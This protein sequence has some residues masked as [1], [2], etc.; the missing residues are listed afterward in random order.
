MHGCL[1][2]GWY[3]LV[4]RMD[5]LIL[6]LILPSPGLGTE[7]FDAF[8]PEKVGFAV[9]FEE[10]ILPY[11]VV[12]VFVLPGETLTLEVLDAA[13]GSEYAL[14]TSAGSP[15]QAA[16]RTW[17]WKAPQ[18]K[19][20]YTLR[21]MNSQSMESITLYAFVMIPYS[22]LKGEYLNGYRIGRYPAI[23]L[24]QLPIYKPPIGF[25]EVTRENE[26]TLVAPHFKLKQF[27]SK[28][29]GGY[30][31]Y[32]VLKERLLLKLELLLEKVNE[33]GYRCDTFHIMSGFRTPYYN[34]AI[35][36]VKYS[37]HLWGGAADIFIDEDPKDDMMDD[38]NRD[39]KMNYMDAAVLYD[40][41]DDLYGKPF[42]RLFIGGL[43]RYK[44]TDSHGPFIHV[45]VRGFR[46][47]WGD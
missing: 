8:S 9:K 34:K 45:D 33:K 7:P 10:E 1:Q 3:P 44:K 36:N 41:V 14:Q 2:R 26:E 20:L 4:L 31:K 42:Y 37:L 27:I 17:H 24:R 29:G 18:G 25:I 40:I 46:A 35:G 12:G 11:R 15:T 38:L 39:G 13:L 47:R 5:V 32:V 28:Q 6:L 22:H 43:G 21:I 30:P 23:P 16:P 19:G